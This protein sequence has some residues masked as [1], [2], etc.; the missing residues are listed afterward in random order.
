MKERFKV[1]PRQFWK[2]DDWAIQHYQELVGEYPNQW[3]AVWKERVVSANEDLGKV[4]RTAHR[5]VGSKPIP[6]IFVESGSHVYK[7]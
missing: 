2:D 5:L 7:N 1:P 4:K 3:V 6:Y